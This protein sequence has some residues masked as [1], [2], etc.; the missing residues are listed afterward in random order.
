M[1]KE[2]IVEI[3][4][5]QLQLPTATKRS[6]VVPHMC[7]GD[8]SQVDDVG[9][10][11]QRVEDFIRF[12]T[13]EEVLELSKVFSCV[14]CVFRRNSIFVMILVIFGSRLARMDLYVNTLGKLH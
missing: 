5:A 11:Q 8:V 13:V 1:R 4:S 14:G 6:K 3:F 9:I 10:I 7:S 12:G 2:R